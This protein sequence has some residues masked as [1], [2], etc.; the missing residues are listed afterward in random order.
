M[1]F[2]FR[3]VHPRFLPLPQRR[4]RRTEGRRSSRTFGN[5]LFFKIRRTN[6]KARRR[7]VRTE[8]DIGKKPRFTKRRETRFEGREGSPPLFVRVRDGFG[9]EF[10][11]S[12]G[13]RSYEGESRSG[14]VGFHE[15]HSN[16][17]P[18]QVP[19]TRADQKRP[20][21]E[22]G[23]ERMAEEITFANEGKKAL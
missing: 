8:L 21:N 4:P 12:D 10:V 11:E 1:N 15:S 14:S 18:R 23:S 2:G 22:L 5:V 9:C 17:P 6:R 7:P 19:R 3:R 20:G 16:R 13:P